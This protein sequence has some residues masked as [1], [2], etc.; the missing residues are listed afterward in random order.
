MLIHLEKF[1]LL[2]LQIKRKEN[3]LN[4]KDHN[5]DQVPHKLDQRP[6][7][8]ILLLKFELLIFL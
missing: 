6:I 7:I 1:F 5:T 3:I 4:G 8:K 2:S